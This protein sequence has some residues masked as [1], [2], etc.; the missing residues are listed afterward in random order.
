MFAHIP[1]FA[2]DPILSLMEAY[3]ADSRPQKANLSIGLYYDD[4]GRIPVLASIGAASRRLSEQHGPHT[5]LPM[6]G[7]TAYRQALQRLV[8]GADSPALQKKRVATIQS[9]G[10][11]GALRIGA[12]FLKR[13][14]PG[15]AVWISDPSWE[16]HQVLFAGAGLAVHT[17]PYYDPQT[18]GLRFDDML[19]TIGGLPA[20][21]AVLLQPSCHNPTGIDLSREQWANLIAVLRQRELIPFLDMAYQGFGEGVEEDA[22]AVRGLVEAGVSF[23]VSNSFS[24]NFS[25]YG[26]RCGGLSVVTP[27]EDEANRVLGQLKA[28]VRRVYSSPPLHGAQLI[29]AVLVDPELAL[30]WSA[31]VTRMRERIMGMRHLLQERLQHCR[32]RPAQFPCRSFCA[33]SALKAAASSFPDSPQTRQGRAHGVSAG[34]GW[35]PRAAQGDHRHRSSRI[36]ASPRGSHLEDAC[37]R[38]AEALAI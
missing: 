17:Y 31:E 36:T 25:L 22:W 28:A 33:G 3:Q 5:Y 24:K 10:G 37:S 16:N 14:F 30:L 12:E 38:T 4:D 7:M 34:V 20:R 32:S 6:E 1:A 27:D 13:Y 8:F 21:S 9:I 26:E 18:N 23:L 11:S 2:G 19:A 29:S 35:Q 15:S